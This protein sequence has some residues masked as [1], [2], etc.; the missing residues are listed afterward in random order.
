MSG[1]QWKVKSFATT[2][3]ALITTLAG[4]PQLSLAQSELAVTNDGSHRVSIVYIAPSNSIF[5]APYELLKDR[6]ALEKVQE[7]LSPVRWTEDL[8]IKTAECGVV[9]SWYTR[10]NLKPTITICYEFLH[11][12]LDTAK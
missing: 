5:Q 9:N 10:E 7:I 2:V 11:H 6:R 4:T 12:I 8:T 3:L 1:S